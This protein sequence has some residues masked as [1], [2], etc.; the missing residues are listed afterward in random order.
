MREEGTPA[1]PTPGRDG[2]VGMGNGPA[3]LSK[4]MV[5]SFKISV[6]DNARL[7]G[8]GKTK[9]RDVGAVVRNFN[10]GFVRQ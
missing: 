5:S 4:F 6:F 3:I 8:N 1:V 2:A 10:D 7:N 9:A